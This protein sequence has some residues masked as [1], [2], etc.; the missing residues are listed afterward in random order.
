MVICLRSSGFC[1]HLPLINASPVASGEPVCIVTAAILLLWALPIDAARSW[2]SQIG[3]AHDLSPFPVP[4]AQILILILLL[5]LH[6]IKQAA[7]GG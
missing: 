2:E 6:P 7:A 1:I 3:W 5:L 4:T